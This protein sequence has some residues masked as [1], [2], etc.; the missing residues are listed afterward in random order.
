MF[1]AWDLYRNPA[2]CKQF[3]L[4]MWKSR[5]VHIHTTIFTEQLAVQDEVL[6]CY[7]YMY[8][9]KNHIPV[10]DLFY[11]ENMQNIGLGR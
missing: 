7:S 6:L 9:L 3:C 5:P 4:F 2:N 10:M 11:V 1:L 8:V